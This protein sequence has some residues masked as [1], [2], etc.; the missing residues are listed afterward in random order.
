M[1]FGLTDLIFRNKRWFVLLFLD[2]CPPE[3]WMLS[4]TPSLGAVSARL[5]RTTPP[6]SER[7]FSALRNKPS[8]WI[9]KHCPQLQK[10]LSLYG[11]GRSCRQRRPGEPFRITNSYGWRRCPTG[12]GEGSWWRKGRGM[13]ALQVRNFFY[14]PQ[15][16]QIYAGRMYFGLTDLIFRNKRWFVLLFLE[17]CPPKVIDPKIQNWMSVPQK[18]RCLSL[19]Y[20]P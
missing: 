7:H 5:A 18:Y 8:Q 20:V 3:Y 17:V 11:R 6:V 1:Y 15:M 13:R 12:S 19:N 9:E 4:P 2:V 16:T 10:N 14:F